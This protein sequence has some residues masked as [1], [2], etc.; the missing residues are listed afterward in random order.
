LLREIKL[1]L[2]IFEFPVYKETKIQ[3]AGCPKKKKRYIKVIE[4]EGSL[5]FVYKF[6]K[7]K[8]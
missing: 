1:R 6:L 8:I 2:I 4:G 5:A 7:K 3:M